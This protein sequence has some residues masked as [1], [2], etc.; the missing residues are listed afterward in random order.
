MLRRC[1]W[2]R[3]SRGSKRGP[4]LVMAVRPAGVA[5]RSAALE[6]TGGRTGWDGLLP[7]ET[8]IAEWP[9]HEPEPTGYWLSNLSAHT[10]LRHLAAHRRPAA[11]RRRLRPAGRRSDV[12]AADGRFAAAPQPGPAAHAPG[13]GAGRHGLLLGGHPVPPAPARHHRDDRPARRP[14][15]TPQKQR[16]GG[17]RSY[18]GRTTVERAINLVKQNRAVA[19]RYD[20]RA[21]VYDGTIQLAAIRIRLR[22][23]TRS[24]NTPYAPSPGQ[25]RAHPPRA[26][27]LLQPAV[28]GRRPPIRIGPIPAITQED[29]HPHDPLTVYTAVGGLPHAETG[30]APQRYSPH[31]T[32]R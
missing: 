16:R 18:R 17:R 31:P 28:H 23:L 22:D 27:R 21:A 13:P 4:F 1:T 25:T 24:T 14:A 5:A 6:R 26:G 32:D 10:P 29:P 3:G 7:A 30:Q 9:P 15:P 2:R 11:H 19:T 20:T 8:L 12:R